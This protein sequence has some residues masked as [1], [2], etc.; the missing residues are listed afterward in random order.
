MGQ[1]EYLLIYTTINTREGRWMVMIPPKHIL[2]LH[3]SVP[4]TTNYLQQDTNPCS[5]FY[6]FDY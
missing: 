2:H 4:P 1:R 6:K 3:A 5:S